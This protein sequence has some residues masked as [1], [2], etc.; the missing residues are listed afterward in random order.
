MAWAGGTFT[1]IDGPT[2][3]QD[4]AAGGIGITATLHDTAF[5]DL[6]TSGINECL[7]KAGQ[8]T[9]TANLPMGGFRHTGC[10]NAVAD[11]DYATLGQIKGGVTFNSSAKIKGDFSNATVTNRTA[12]QTSTT[13][14]STQLEVLPDGTGTLAQITMIGASDAANASILQVLQFGSTES[15]IRTSK[16]GTGTFT[17]MTF[18]TSD[19]ERVKIATNG[20]ISIG[21]VVARAQTEIYGGGQNTAALTDAGNRGGTLR[22]IDSGG[23]AGNGGAITFGTSQ[24]D[25][26]NSAGFAAI[27]GLLASGVSNTTGHLAFATRNATGDTA[28]T[29]RMRIVDNGNVWL[30]SAIATT[31]TAA[32]LFV[33]TA[34]NYNI[35]RSTSSLRYKTNVQDYTKG[36]TAVQALRPVSFKGKTDGDKVFAGFIAEEVDATGLTEFVVYDEEG[37]PD[38]LAYSHMVAL[39]TKAIQELS[40]RVEALEAQT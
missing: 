8:N 31:A 17:P 19:I 40:A 22:I 36:L 27:K 29:E 20:D 12:F 38:S 14:G 10:G 7:N 21:G 34:D 6:A 15:S 9:P 30:S 35:K 4:D 1:R 18:Y 26:V 3:W 23:G 16:R 5:N 39:L 13:N 28:L 25:T 24:A 33:D 11:S 37:R 2:G 32:N